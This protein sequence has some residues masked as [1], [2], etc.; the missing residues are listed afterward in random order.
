MALETTP[1]RQLCLA[2]AG[3]ALTL[4]TLSIG[5]SGCNSGGR[6]SA[7]TAA[8]TSSGATTATSSGTVI[9]ATL[10]KF[11]K[12]DVT[13]TGGGAVD[14]QPRQPSGGYAAGTT[15]SLQAKPD[16]GSVLK[17][18]GGSL[19]SDDRYQLSFQIT[20]DTSLAPE[21]EIAVA[22]TPLAGFSVTGETSWVAPLAVQFTD[23]STGTVTRYAWEFGDGGSSNVA[24][25]LYTYTTPGTYTV[26]LRVY[27]DQ[28]QAGA[29]VVQEKLITVA[30]PSQGSRYWY[31]G[32]QYGN[33]AVENTAAERKLAQEILTTCNRERATAGVPPLSYDFQAE[34]AA[35][36]HSIDMA[37][38]GY[39]DHVT[40][41]GWQPTDRLRATG[42][43]GYVGAGE[44]LAAGQ[45]TPADVMKS[46]MNSAGHRANILSPDFTHLGV[47][48]ATYQGSTLIWTQVFLKR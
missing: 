47:G 42:A 43:K 14:V 30:D 15:V 23:Q 13:I 38:R 17:S 20:A 22:G 44:N 48:V 12:V 37:K 31:T 34:S 10:P 9:K 32:A 28:G 1:W 11:Y 36:G 19:G 27:D 24:S 29:P 7:A 16:S 39:F 18:W 4:L 41:E 46:W 3:C 33:P 21:F 25:P 8:A 6:P 5:A 40:P 2:S 26:V 45:P 35:K